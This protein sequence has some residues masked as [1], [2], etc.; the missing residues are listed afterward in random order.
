MRPFPFWVGR[1]L[2][3]G[4]LSG[5]ALNRLP[6]ELAGITPV[7]RRRYTSNVAD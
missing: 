6:R 7:D 4:L 5:L 1:Y 2:P 3:T